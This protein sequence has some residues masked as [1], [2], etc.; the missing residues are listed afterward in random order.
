MK[1]KILTALLVFVYIVHSNAQHWVE[2]M[3]DP[4]ANYYSISQEFENYWKNHDKNEKGKGYKVFRR[5]E[6]FVSP[7]VYPSGD[8]S[9]LALTGK[10]FEAWQKSNKPVMITGKQKGGSAQIASV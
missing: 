4:N 8:L 5:W 3:Q 1:S 9:Q 7:R 10:N 6:H 2:M